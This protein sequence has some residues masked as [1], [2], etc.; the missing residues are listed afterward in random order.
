MESAASIDARRKLKNSTFDKAFRVVIVWPLMA[1]CIFTVITIVVFHKMFFMPSG[2]ELFGLAGL[3][4]GLQEKRWHNTIGYKTVAV[5]M[6]IGI[7]VGAYI[8]GG[9]LLS[10]QI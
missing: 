9:F 3:G 1:A 4:G 10:G 6:I 8:D 7:A 2:W 5:L